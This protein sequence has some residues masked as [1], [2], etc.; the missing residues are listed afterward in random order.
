MDNQYIPQFE[1]VDREQL[2]VIRSLSVGQR[3]EL[4]LHARELAV[5]LIRGRLHKRYPDLSINKLNMLVLE[6]I[7]RAERPIPR[8]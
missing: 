1:P 2:E 7:D 5:G 8:F 6:E 4:M 3:I